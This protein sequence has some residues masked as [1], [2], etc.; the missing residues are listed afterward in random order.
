V[1]LFTLERIEITGNRKGNTVN[2]DRAVEIYDALKQID[3]VCQRV[4]LEFMYDEQDGNVSIYAHDAD[5]LV[6]VVC[7]VL[8]SFDGGL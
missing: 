6:D 4:N 1:K 2:P 5:S 8:T 7:A 3:E